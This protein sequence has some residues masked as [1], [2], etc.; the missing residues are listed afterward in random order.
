MWH[1]EGEKRSRIRVE[2]RETFLWLLIFCKW[3]LLMRKSL[4]RALKE[5]LLCDF[6]IARYRLTE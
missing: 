1:R 5:E 4:A 2:Y 3:K 6:H